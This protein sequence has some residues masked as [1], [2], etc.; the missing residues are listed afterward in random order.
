MKKENENELLN[1][2]LN[3]N[4]NT[5]KSANLVSGIKL[6]FFHLIYIL[7]QNHIDEFFLESVFIILQFIKLISFPLCGIFKDGWKKIL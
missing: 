7:I 4:K 1:L 2:N 5:N 3:K 6:H